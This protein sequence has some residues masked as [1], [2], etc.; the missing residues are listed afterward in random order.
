MY[1][2]QY[3]N[4]ASMLKPVKPR[5]D[6]SV[7]F[8]QLG[9]TSA[10]WHRYLLVSGKVRHA[11]GQRLNRCEVREKGKREKVRERKGRGKCPPS[12][13]CFQPPFFIYFLKFLLAK[14]QQE[15]FF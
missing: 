12:F 15:H 6:T 4:L 1:I 5:G 11:Q 13:L 14:I 9:C 2:K 10:S 8:L 7:A 3:R